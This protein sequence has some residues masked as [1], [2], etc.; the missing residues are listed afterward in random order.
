VRDEELRSQTDYSSGQKEAA[1]R[2]LVEIV[3]ILHEYES[4]ILIVGGWVP[5]LLFPKQNHVGSIDVDLLVNHLALEEASYATIERILL[6]N[7]YIK[8]A[9]KYFTFV[10]KVKVSDVEYTVDLDI[11][12]GMYGGTAENR[13]SQHIQG[14][15]AFKAT[16][17]NFAFEVPPI[18]VALNAKRPDGALDSGIVNVIAIVPYLIMKTAALGRGKAKDAYDIYFCIRNFDGGVNSL[19]IEF[20]PFLHHSLVQDMLVKLSGKFASHEHAGPAD[21]VSFLELYGDEDIEMTKRD[22][23][24]QINRLIELL[25]N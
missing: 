1:H 9:E 10:K 11:M 25:Q 16:G 17:G 19:A 3:N 2:I 20:R 8:H 24:E 5:D 18:K 13:K 15:K 23:F 21:I 6:K 22:S 12:A 14:L 4:D 7:D